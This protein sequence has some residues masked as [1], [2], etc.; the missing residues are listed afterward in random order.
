MKPASS[1]LRILAGVALIAGCATQQERIQRRIA[2]KADFF[3]TLAPEKQQLVRE[4]RIEA[5]DPTEAAWIV[6]G[7]PDRIFQK[8]TVSGT[9][10]VWSYISEDISSVNTLHPVYHPIR[11]SSGRTVWRQDLFWSTDTYHHPY[12]YLRIEIEDG[13]VLSLET[14]QP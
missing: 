10:E 14:A 5:G 7:R 11:L 13:R 1:I 4:G 2:E 9:N 3:A 6:Y 12:E 8:V